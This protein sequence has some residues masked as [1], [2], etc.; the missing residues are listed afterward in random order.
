VLWIWLW[1][2]FADHWQCSEC[3]SWD[4]PTAVAALEIGGPAHARCRKRL[5]CQRVKQWSVAE[6]WSQVSN[7]WVLQHST[8]QSS[9]G[10]RV[11]LSPKANTA[12]RPAAAFFSELLLSHGQR[13]FMEL[14]RSSC[15]KGEGGG[16]VAERHA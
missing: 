4:T 9:I 7:R 2:G 12:Q 15:S 16:T 1:L 6:P 13:A 14:G 5:Y 3:V 8:Q 10:K 11:L